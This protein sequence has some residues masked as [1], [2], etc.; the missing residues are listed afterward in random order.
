MAY[1]DY[2][3]MQTSQKEEI[4]FSHT[5]DWV[6]MRKI[7]IVQEVEVHGWLLSG[8]EELFAALFWLLYCIGAN[9]QRIISGTKNKS[10]KW[11]CLL[12]SRFCHWM[13]IFNY[14]VAYCACS[15]WSLENPTKLQNCWSDRQHSAWNWRDLSSSIVELLW[16]SLSL[17]SQIEQQS[18]KIRDISGK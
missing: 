16:T 15:V 1:Q 12:G 17:L 13:E 14:W 2:Q 9:L 4:G 18:W 11:H 3:I 6:R 5:W 7:I 10:L 8:S